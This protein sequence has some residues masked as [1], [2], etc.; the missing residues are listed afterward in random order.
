[1]SQ[2]WGN[3]RIIAFIEDY[4]VIKKSL[5]GLAYMNLKETGPRQKDLLLQIHLMIMHRMII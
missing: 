4:K 3:M 2:V 5:T 1:M